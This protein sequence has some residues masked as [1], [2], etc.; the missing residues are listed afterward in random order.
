MCLLPSKAKLVETFIVE[1]GIFFACFAH[2]FSQQLWQRK[3]TLLQWIFNSLPFCIVKTWI[4]LSFLSDCISV[5]VFLENLNSDIIL[6]W[7]KIIR[8]MSALHWHIAMSKFPNLIAQLVKSRASQVSLCLVSN[9]FIVGCCCLKMHVHKERNEN[10][11]LL[12]FKSLWLG[13]LPLMELGSDAYKIQFSFAT[14]MFGSS[15]P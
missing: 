8:N 3:N 13:P 7:D 1:V 12:S 2:V 10:F 6:L 11:L 14:W 5:F 9:N 15:K 4:Y